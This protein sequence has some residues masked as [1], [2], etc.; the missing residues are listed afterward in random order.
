M[1]GS[2]PSWEFVAWVLVSNIADNYVIS[3]QWFLGLILTSS[4]PGDIW[5]CVETVLVVTIKE[6]LLVFSG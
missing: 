5:Q 1:W 3:C 4:F 2:Q 6:L